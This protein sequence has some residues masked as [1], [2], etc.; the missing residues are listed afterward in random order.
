[1]NMNHVLLWKEY[2]QQR[3]IWLAIASLAIFMVVVMALTLGQGSGLDVFRDVNITPTLLMTVLVLGVAYAIVS[4]SLLLAVEKEDRT[5]DFLDGLSGQRA[6]VWR[7][8]ATAGAL[9]TLAQ[10]TVLVLLIMALGI[11]SWRTGLIILYWCLDGLAWGLLGGALCQRVLTAVLAGI[12]F[13]A[14]SWLLALFVNTPETLYLGKAMLAGAGVLYSRKVFCRDDLSRQSPR[15]S[16]FAIPLPAGWRVLLWLSFRQGRWV[17]VGGLG[18]AVVLGLTVNLAPLILWPIGT[19][20]L[21]LT[22]GLAV[23]CPDQGDGNR[24]LGAQRFSPGRI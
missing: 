1:M 12:V 4:G 8:K 24:F 7:K 11:G 10:G 13:M 15:K 2:R 5:L 16:R 14:A 3:A 17:L 23:F 6:P 22:C 19:L 21:G 9:F 20:L 18:F